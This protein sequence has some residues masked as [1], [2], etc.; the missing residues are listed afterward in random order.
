[1]KRCLLDMDGV[2][3]DFVRGA[4][5]L[6]N[7]MNPYY[8]SDFEGFY[9]NEAWNMKPADFWRGMDR[10]FWAGLDWMADGRLLFGFIDSHFGP[11]NTCI[12]TSPCSN[13]GCY[14]GKQ[15]WIRAHLPKAY[16]RRFLIG[17]EKSYCAGP[18]RVLIDDRDENIE[19]F[20]KFGGHGILVPRPWNKNRGLKTPAYMHVVGRLINDSGR[21]HQ[22]ST[23]S[24]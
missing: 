12:L 21:H 23:A 6:H 7:Q 18:D 11:E 8:N 5:R 14:D 16:H 2:I 13:D 3:A 20:I 1:M 22:A 10:D 17:P 19:E 9:F 15:D 24:N 4:C